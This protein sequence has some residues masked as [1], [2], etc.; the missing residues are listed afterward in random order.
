MTPSQAS[1]VVSAGFAG[2]RDEKI[3]GDGHVPPE[4]VHVA[5]SEAW[6]H[7]L[8]RRLLTKVEGLEAR[9][10]VVAEE[11]D[12]EEL[13]GEVKELQGK[14]SIE[15]ND[16]EEL[17]GEVKRL[18]GKLSSEEKDSAD[19]RGEIKELQGKMSSEEKDSEV[20]ELEGK[21]AEGNSHSGG[22]MACGVLVVLIYA[23]LAGFLFKR[24]CGNYG[25]LDSGKLPSG[26]AIFSAL[27]YWIAM[28]ST[29][30]L[31]SMHSS[32]REGTPDTAYF[33]YGG[34]LLVHTVCGVVIAK[35]KPKL[36][37]M[38]AGSMTGMM[39]SLPVLC[40]FTLLE[41]LDQGTD[42]FFVGVARACTDEVAGPWLRS[43]EAVPMVGPTVS[44]WLALLGFDSFTLMLYLTCTYLPQLVLV[45]SFLVPFFAIPFA[46]TI[47]VW[48][49]L[50][51]RVGLFAMIS[52]F[53]LMF[54]AGLVEMQ[55]ESWARYFLQEHLSYFSGYLLFEADIDIELLHKYNDNADLNTDPNT[56]KLIFGFSKLLFENLLQSLMQASFISLTFDSMDST[57]RT[58]ALV[59]LGLS[60]AT[61]THKL[62]DVTASYWQFRGRSFV[63]SSVFVGLLYFSYLILLWVVAKVYYSF[64]CES[65]VW[66]L[67]SGCVHV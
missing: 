29:L 12:L 35:G 3:S 27:M 23:F 36:P 13:R 16:L 52:V 25:A 60:F 32:C 28:P 53:G 58:K 15:E 66:N 10:E 4:S 5:E 59:S 55:F 37:A 42:V 63:L 46:G 41:H 48:A 34:F 8:S 6:R 31:L 17:R 7:L 33:V 62:I 19:L 26:T 9:E 38:W 22:F 1:S 39:S 56:K 50:G 43:W 45:W 18:Q 11:Q 64:V 65:H 61:S 54:S 67:S 44:R 2:G 51:W 57:G 47:M 14:S 20:K 40:F 21:V 30:F 24:F 49:V